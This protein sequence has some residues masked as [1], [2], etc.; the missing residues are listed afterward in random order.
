[1]LYKLLGMIVWKG[2]KVVLRRKYGGTYAPKPLVAGAILAIVAL[3]AI[4]ASR[5]DNG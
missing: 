5:R 4:L 1:M 3:V 2:A